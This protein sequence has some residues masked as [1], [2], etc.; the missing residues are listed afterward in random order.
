[1][2]PAHEAN[3]ATSGGITSLIACQGAKNKARRETPAGHLFLHEGLARERLQLG[4]GG[5]RE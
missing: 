3:L 1:M 4:G 5:S 2:G